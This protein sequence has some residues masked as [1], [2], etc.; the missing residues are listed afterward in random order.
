MVPI[1]RQ[2][3][4]PLQKSNAP[5]GRAFSDGLF[6]TD[7][8]KTGLGTGD[9]TNC[10]E[11]GGLPGTQCCQAPS[12]RG[13][14]K[15]LA[16]VRGAGPE[17]AAAWRSQAQAKLGELVLEIVVLVCEKTPASSYLRFGG[18]GGAT[19]SDRASGPPMWLARGSKTD[20][21]CCD[22]AQ[23]RHEVGPS[24]TTAKGSNFGLRESSICSS[25]FHPREFLSLATSMN[26]ETMINTPLEN[27]GGDN[28]AAV[29][30][31]R[32]PFP[33]KLDGADHH[34]SDHCGLAECGPVA[35]NRQDSTA[36]PGHRI[37]FRQ[38]RRQWA[39]YSCLRS[40]PS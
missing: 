40:T 38:H 32:F 22:I 28:N 14:A 3:K 29:P 2:I 36:R 17:N 30:F 18:F 8:K 7:R 24:C 9:Q 4:F 37:F 27:A 21:L 10:L 20:P 33:H 1:V 34:F 23:L 16:A 13:G 6:L 5:V 31:L 26:R 15:G 35:A 11:R 12:S 19:H 39:S 25:C